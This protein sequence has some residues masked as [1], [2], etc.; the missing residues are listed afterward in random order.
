MMIPPITVIMEGI[1]LIRT[2]P[3]IVDSKGVRNIKFV[4]VVTFLAREI[5]IAQ[6]EYARV[7]GSIPRQKA[8]NIC[9]G[10]ACINWV[11]PAGA[12]GIKNRVP[13]KILYVVASLGG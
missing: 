12:K 1:S 7:P 8:L 5:D 2:K 9:I 3:I 6:K 4:T 13:A 11:K 10:G